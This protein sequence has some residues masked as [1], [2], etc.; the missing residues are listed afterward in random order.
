MSI[1]GNDVIAG[2]LPRAEQEVGQT[3]DAGVEDR[4]AQPL[5]EVSHLQGGIKSVPPLAVWVQSMVMGA[6]V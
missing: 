1:V 3:G 2:S 6:G 5:V 4:V